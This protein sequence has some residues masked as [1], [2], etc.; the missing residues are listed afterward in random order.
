MEKGFQE[1]HETIALHQVAPKVFMILAKQYV[2]LHGWRL[3]FISETGL[4]AYTQHGITSWNAELQ[5][6]IEDQVATL[7]SRSVEREQGDSSQHKHLVQQWVKHLQESMMHISEST[8]Q[9][10]DTLETRVFQSQE[11]VRRQ[12]V[13]TLKDQGFNILRFLI[14]GKQFFATPFLLDL[15]IILF[16]VMI[17]SGVH[18]IEPDGNDLLLWG[19]NL[20]SRVMNGELWRLITACFIHI[21]VMHLLM[22][23]YA[24][25]YIGLQ[26]EP[27]LGKRKFLLAY[28]I[29]GLL[30]STVSIYW[31]DRTISAGASGAIFGMYGV[32]LAL[33]LTNLLEHHTRKSLLSSILIFVIYNLVNGLQAGIDNAAHIGGLLSGIVVGMVLIP[34]LKRNSV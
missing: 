4:I 5:I 3:H 26:L 34:G 7:S 33:L 31:H 20:R 28:F 24:L 29:T 25:V 11:E 19:A 17:L 9:E 30:A 22:N 32:F 14:P 1:Y 15:N 10:A 27:L 16:V 23:M 2:E 18:P 12:P 8:L 6:L 21:G 13:P